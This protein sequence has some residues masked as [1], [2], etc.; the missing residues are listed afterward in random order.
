VEL[1]RVDPDNIWEELTPILFSGEESAAGSTA[2]HAV[3]QSSAV[4]STSVCLS[5]RISQK[6]HSFVARSWSVGA[7]RCG[8]G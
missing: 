2:L 4:K 3:T 8:E 7:S 5:V 1:G 6:L